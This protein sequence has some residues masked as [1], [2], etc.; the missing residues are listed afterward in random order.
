MLEKSLAKKKQVLL[1]DLRL[2]VEEAKSFLPVEYFC[3]DDPSNLRE[4]AR[5]SSTPLLFE[6][7]DAF[8]DVTKIDQ[9][10]SSSKIDVLLP[11]ASTKYPI[12]NR[13][14]VVAAWGG[15]TT[16]TLPDSSERSKTV[17]GLIAIVGETPLLGTFVGSSPGESVSPVESGTL[18]GALVSLGAR[19]VVGLVVPIDGACTGENDGISPREGLDTDG[20]ENVGVDGFESGDLVEPVGGT[21]P[22]PP[23]GRLGL[24]PYDMDNGNEKSCRTISYSCASFL[25]EN[26]FIIKV[27]GVIRQDT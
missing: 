19:P 27:S 4:G 14:T 11:N 16:T 2:K 23:V 3:E 15:P 25:S 26:H 1:E 9:L 8:T 7:R 20:V 18:E 13:T 17:V 24:S 22:K 21:T 12:S 5:P 10:M 6:F